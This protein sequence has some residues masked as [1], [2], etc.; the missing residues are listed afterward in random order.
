MF[1]SIAMMNVGRCQLVVNGVSCHV[2]LQ[3]SGGF[4][5]KTLELRV[6]TSL[7]KKNDSALVCSNN[8]MALATFHWFCMDVVAVI[9]IQNKQVGVASSRRD[10]E[11]ASCITVNAASILLTVSIK[12]VTEEDWW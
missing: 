11:V 10:K 2:L 4:I 8:V 6:E 9:I 1:I 5:V 7:G 12:M 3:G